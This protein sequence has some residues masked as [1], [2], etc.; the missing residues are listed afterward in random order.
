MPNREIKVEHDVPLPL[1][2]SLSRYPWREMQV[3]DSFLF[4]ANV[5][6]PY[7]CARVWSSSVV[8]PGRKYIARK[9]DE[10]IRCW[11]IA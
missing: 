3:G 11:R 2:F 10:G 8:C 1:P 5:I 4:P 9:T 6:N 7:Q